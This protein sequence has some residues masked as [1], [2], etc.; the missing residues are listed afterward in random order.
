MDLYLAPGPLHRAM[1]QVI[2]GCI[3]LARGDLAAAART[4]LAA[5]DALRSAR[6]EDQHQLPF[7][8]L[9]ILLALDTDGPAAALAA[10]SATMDRFDMAGGSP[11]YVWP[12]VTAG[13]SAVLAAARQAAAA[14][15]ERL[16]DEAAALADRLRTV[17]EKLETVR[18]GPARLTS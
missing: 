1:L 15:D 13:A 18:P 16:R 11:R 9:E 7:A 12:V 5:R 3:T 17:A 14:H 6:Y 2:A 4:V 10:A 8:R